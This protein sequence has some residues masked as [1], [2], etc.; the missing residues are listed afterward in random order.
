MKKAILLLGLILISCSKDTSDSETIIETITIEPTVKTRITETTSS[1]CEYGGIDILVYNDENNNG[2]KDGTEKTYLQQTIC[3]SQ[4][5]NVQT[6]IS[7]ANLEEC[8][9]SGVIILVFDDK[10]DNGVYDNGEEV[11]YEG[12]ECYPQDSDGDNIIDS[13]DQCPDTLEGEDVD[14]NG[15]ALSQKDTDNDGVTDDIDQCPETP[16]GE[17]VDQFGCPEAPIYVAENGVTIKARDWAEVGT[18]WTIDGTEYTVVDETT[19]RQMVNNNEDVTKVVTTF[20]TD[21]SLLFYN[22]TLFNQG[23]GSWDTSNVISMSE[24]FAFA[25]IFNQDIGYWDTSSVVTTSG[26][27]LRA[28]G[29]NQDIGSWSTSNVTNMSAMFS[30]ARIFNKPIGSWDVSNVLT[31]SSMFNKAQNFNQDISQWNVGNI[32]TMERMFLDCPF[33]Q[34]ISSWNV[35]SVTNMKEMFAYNGN[36]NQDLSS[37]NVSQVTACG[38]FNAYTSS[39]SWTLPK[40]NFTNC[41]PD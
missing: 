7:E 19:L 30:Y 35:S 15:C 3:F 8:P 28:Y 38:G 1:Q 11:F 34:E 40:P 25:E 9:A 29:F 23:I 12:T 18:T 2:T 41:N 4:T 24:T 27:F 5:T 16:E 6:V 36:F 21:M 31:M 14:E 20:V 22:K 32:E 10:N 13:I 33:N 26:M 17:N 37:W 39:T